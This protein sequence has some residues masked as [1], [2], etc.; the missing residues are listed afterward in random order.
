[1]AEIFMLFPEGKSKALTLSYDDGVQTDERL[2]RIMQAHGLKGTFNLNSGRYAK[3][4]TV[5]PPETYFRR[6]SRSQATRMYTDSGMEVAVHGLTHPFLE[7]LTTG[8]CCYEVC[9]DRRNLEDQ[10]QRIV[11]GM[12]YPFGTYNSEVV[13]CLRQCGIA[14][15]RT[16]VSSHSFNLPENWLTWAATCHHNDPMLEGLT[17]QFIKNEVNNE[18]WLF[19]LWGHSYEFERDDNW[20]LIERFAENIGNRADVW[21][22]TN[23]EVYDYVQAYRQLQ[24]SVCGKRLHN[25][26]AKTLW[27]RYNTG[28][29]GWDIQ[30][31]E[32][33]QTIL[34]PCVC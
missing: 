2:I 1:M 26:T 21:Y 7:Q 30:K 22:A 31:I 20:E 27:L 16:V 23:M 17:Q 33:G 15:A 6:F 25:P 28:C 5:Y 12:A 10:F 4:D 8:A 11:R 19:Y 3:E 9:T 24:S 32:P 29:N 18:P 13:E 14:Y 34:L